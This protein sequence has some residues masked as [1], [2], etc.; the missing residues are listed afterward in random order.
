MGMKA[1][2]HAIKPFTDKV[3]ANARIRVQDKDVPSNVNMIFNYIRYFNSLP[4]D[5]TMINGH[6]LSEWKI[7]NE[8]KDFILPNS[9]RYE[10]GNRTYIDL[11]VRDDFKLELPNLN[12]YNDLLS[13][14]RNFFKKDTNENYVDLASLRIN[15]S[16]E[17]VRHLISAKGAVRYMDNPYI[18]IAVNDGVRCLF[19]SHYFN[20]DDKQIVEDFVAKLQL[21]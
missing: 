13:K 6:S 9:V 4:E 11:M 12:H 3:I 19:S 1:V 5:T 18:P 8:F 21:V 10:S 15:R 2:E 14:F 16:F 7:L 20:S 17:E